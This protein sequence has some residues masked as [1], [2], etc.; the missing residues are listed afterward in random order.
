[1]QEA[2]LPSPDIGAKGYH[3]RRMAANVISQLEVV[4]MSYPNGA[5]PGASKVVAFFDACSAKIAFNNVTLNGASITLSGQ[6][7]T[8]SRST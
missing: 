7:I 8:Y 4:A 5:A 2:S 1:M 6:P 3:L